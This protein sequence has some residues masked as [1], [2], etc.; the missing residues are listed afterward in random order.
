LTDEDRE[1]LSTTIAFDAR[2]RLH[3]KTGPAITFKQAQKKTHDYNDRSDNHDEEMFYWHG[4]QMPKDVV[5][6]HNLITQSRILNE[7]NIEIRRVML[8]HYGLQRF[9]KGMKPVDVDKFGKLYHIQH[10]DYKVNGITRAINMMDTLAYVLVKN[11]SPEPDGTFKD[12]ILRVPPTVRTAKEA[13]AWTFR[14]T[15]REYN[16]AKET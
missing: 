14:K 1:R 7:T 12:Y 9:F 2:G 8:E 5:R 4:V 16:P 11:S 13:I 10:Q 3:H 15:G 6:N